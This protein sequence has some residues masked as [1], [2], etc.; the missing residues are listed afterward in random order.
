[1]DTQRFQFGRSSG[2]ATESKTGHDLLV[3][4]LV[5]LFQEI[6]EFSPPCHKGQEAAPR[7]K[8]L[9]MGSQMIG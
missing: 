6:E 2:S 5:V 8:V 9:A 3:A 1:M 7:G 4:L